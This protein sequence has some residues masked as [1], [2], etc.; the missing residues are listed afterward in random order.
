MNNLPG[1]IDL[2]P[3]LAIIA[4]LAGSGYSTSGLLTW[5]RRVALNSWLS[6]LAEEQR[7]AIYQGMLLVMN[8]AAIL[9]LALTGH[10]TLSWNLAGAVL[11]AALIATGGAHGLYNYNQ[12]TKASD[13]AGFSAPDPTT[14]NGA[15]GAA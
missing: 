5:L 8:Y 15:H 12:K 14:P 11:L 3:V 2:S 13:P 6:S 9:A 7:A 10:Y 1:L 4:T